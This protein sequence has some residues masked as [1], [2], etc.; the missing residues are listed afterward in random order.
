MQYE[1]VAPGDRRPLPKPSV[2]TG[3]GLE[4]LCSVLAG[5]RSA[6]ETDLLRPL[7][8][9]AEELS[10]VNVRRGRLRRGRACRCARSPTTR[11]RPRS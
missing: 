9:E 5:V 11:A 7:I 4:R 8:A 2:D 6:Y 3:M 10:K 1:Q